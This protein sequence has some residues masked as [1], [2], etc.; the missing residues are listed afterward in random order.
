MSACLS[1]WVAPSGS[2]KTVST[3]GREVARASDKGSTR[4]I[5]AAKTIRA[6]CHPKLAMRNTLSGENKN[7]PKEPAAVPAP[8]DTERHAGGS[9]LPNADSTMLNEQPDKPKPSSTPADRLSRPGV[10]AC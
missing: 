6:C 10:F 3:V 1:D 2:L 7:C 4:I 8:S 5:S 9:S